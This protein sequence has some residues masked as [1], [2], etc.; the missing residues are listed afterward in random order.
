M[1]DFFIAVVFS[2]QFLTR[3]PLPVS[4][5]TDKNI[6]RKALIVF[7]LVGWILGGIL[8]F[9]WWFLNAT[10]KFSSLSLA[11][12][13][14]TVETLITGAFHLDG[15]ADSFDAFLSSGTSKDEKLTI[16][17]DSRIGVMG[18]VA[19]I[20]CLM[21]KVAL[22]ND[23]LIQR[24]P[25]ALLLFPVLGRW[26]QVA[27]YVFSPYVREGG[28]GSLFSEVADKKILTASSLFLIPCFIL[29]GILPAFL[30][31]ILFLWL[32]RAYVH[33]QIGGITGDV[34]GSLAVLSEVMLLFSILICR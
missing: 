34:L 1:K 26:S 5:K 9:V 31:L 30:F 24:I 17:K 18:G 6:L 28:L 23:V 33:K 25:A 12:C 4:V 32:Y 13:I 2:I 29:S 20:L 27:F 15:L 16:M 21:L 19:L 7:P 8:F 3:I 22:V 11:A 14:I 10:G